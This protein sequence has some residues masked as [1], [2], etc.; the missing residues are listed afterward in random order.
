MVK[1]LKFSELCMCSR[2]K[3]CKIFM[4]RETKCLGLDFGHYPWSLHENH[5]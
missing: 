2:T 1:V 4:F 3:Y 5:F